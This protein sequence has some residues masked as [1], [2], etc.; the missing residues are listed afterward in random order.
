MAG[1]VALGTAQTA[2]IAA[3]QPQFHMGGM[4]GPSSGLAPDETFVRA[5]QGEA[6]LSTSV[7]NRIGEDGIRNLES[8]GTTKPMGMG[9]T[10]TGQIGY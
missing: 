5:K 7:V 10:S 2:V 8:G 3:E 9:T 4:I 1:A 6:V